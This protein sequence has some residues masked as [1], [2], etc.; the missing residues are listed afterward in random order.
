MVKFKKLYNLKIILMF[1]TIVFYLNTLVY[2]I[3]IQAEIHLRPHLIFNK[4][5]KMKAEEL[6]ESWQKKYGNQADIFL[7]IFY[8]KALESLEARKLIER[9]LD[10][11]VKMSKNNS[12]KPISNGMLY[13]IANILKPETWEDIIQTEA[14]GEL[15]DK[16]LV[17]IIGNGFPDKKKE[18]IKNN[19]VISDTYSSLPESGKLINVPKTIS[20]SLEV[21]VFELQDSC[22]VYITTNDKEFINGLKDIVTEGEYIAGLE[23]FPQPVFIL[24]IEAVKEEDG[25]TQMFIVEV[26]PVIRLNHTHPQELRDFMAGVEGFN[27]LLTQCCSEQIMFTEE[28]YGHVNLVTTGD[29]INR[30]PVIS[31]STALRCYTLFPS[32]YGAKLKIVSWSNPFIKD[33]Q[34]INFAWEF[35]RVE[36]SLQGPIRVDTEEGRRFYYVK[37]VTDYGEMRVVRVLREGTQIGKK[38]GYRDKRYHMGPAKLVAQTVAAYREY[39]KQFLGFDF[40]IDVFIRRISRRSMEEWYNLSYVSEA[41][42]AELYKGDEIEISVEAQGNL[43]DG[44]LEFIMRNIKEAFKNEIYIKGEGHKSLLDTPDVLKTMLLDLKAGQ[45]DVSSGENRT[46]L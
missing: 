21:R 14:R 22:H 26:Q 11:T 6:Y 3:D 13:N 8:R 40:K 28:T 32:L 41:L 45:I 18:G 39:I 42:Q 44:I 12:N 9:I 1:T 30:W 43:P 15:S 31:L 2:G 27:L 19:K 38:G 24:Q 46:D 35:P 33:S 36:P 17:Q 20:D 10:K 4:Q 16:L 25:T 23:G 5:D 34:R 37:E 7:S 29:M